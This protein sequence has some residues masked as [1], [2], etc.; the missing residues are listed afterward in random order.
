MSNF[1]STPNAS[2]PPQFQQQRVQPQQQAAPSQNQAVPFTTL[3]A[4]S[5]VPT[6]VASAVGVSSPTSGSI[7]S[8][9]VVG[10]PTGSPAPPPISSNVN[11]SATPASSSTPVPVPNVSASD[12]QAA[13]T[14]APITTSIPNAQSNTSAPISSS[15]PTA[16][17]AG[18]ASTSAAAATQTE[19]QPSNQDT[20]WAARREEEIAR[21]DRSL[22]ELL[23]MLDGYKPLIPEEVTEY[24]LQRSGFDCSDPRL[25]R[26]LSLVAQK[27]I[28]DLSRDAFHFSKLRVNGAT[29]G[30]GRPAAGVDRNRVVLTMDDLSLALGEHGVNLKAPDYYL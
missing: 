14:S 2:T 29:A 11:G 22:A 8:Q 7:S 9:S 25:K 5:S 1:S 6:P 27:F 24:F 26:L 30:R 12:T 13:I 28:S 23:V 21:R 3:S 10:G 19:P 18:N 4:S 15:G 16:G 17:L 20:F